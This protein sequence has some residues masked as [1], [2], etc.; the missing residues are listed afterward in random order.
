VKKPISIKKSLV[1]IAL[2]LLF[3]TVV[4]PFLLVKFIEISRP[5][6]SEEFPISVNPLEE[7]I[8]EDPEINSYLDESAI[9]GEALAL[10]SLK[11]IGSYF[12]NWA[13]AFMTLLDENNL[14]LATTNKVVNVPSGLRKEEVAQVFGKALNWSEAERKEFLIKL[15]DADLPLAEGS[16]MGGVYAVN[17]DASPL[18]VQTLLNEKFKLEIL[19]RYG[20]EASELVPLETALTVAS[21]IQRET[22]GTED[23]RIVSGIIWNRIFADM[24]L[25]LDATLQYT[26]ANQRKNGIWW[27]RVNPQDKFIPSPYNTYLNTGL[28]PTPIANPSIPAIIAALNPVKTEC[29]FYF[30]DNKGNLHCTSTY[31]EHVALL[32]KI[33]GRGK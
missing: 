21:L 9:F 6:Y 19:S 16:F 26:K 33:Y 14:A 20:A 8:T 24:K 17:K 5:N 2:A 31:E 30:H 15:P 11:A 4:T 23:M 28:P 22:I 10:S 1:R 12:V 25:Q 32:K 29:L 18:E 27:P 13:A 3:L 7:V